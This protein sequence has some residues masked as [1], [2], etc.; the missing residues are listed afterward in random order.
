MWN[1]LNRNTGRDVLEK[2][3]NVA[4]KQSHTGQLYL[5]LNSMKRI[6][7]LVIPDIAF[8]MTLPQ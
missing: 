7:G 3:K 2:C 8:R 4:N 1:K 6:V 5:I